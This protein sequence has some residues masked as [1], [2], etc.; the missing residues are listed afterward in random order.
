MIPYSCWQIVGAKFLAGLSFVTLLVLLSAIV[1]FVLQ[2]VSDDGYMDRSQLIGSMLGLYLV[3]SVLIA[4]SLF[5]SAVFVSSSIALLSAIVVGFILF[6]GFS[7]VATLPF[8]SADFAFL[9]ERMGLQY[10]VDY[11]SKGIISMFSLVYNLSLIYIFLYATQLV[12]KLK[13]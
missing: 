5:C 4:I 6:S 11:L 1:P 8:L 12:V 10:H 7:F 13:K 2:Q 9:L 3:S